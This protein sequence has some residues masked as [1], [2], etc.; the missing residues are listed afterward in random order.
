LFIDKLPKLINIVSKK[1]SIF[2]FVNKASNVLLV[3]GTTLKMVKTLPLSI[4]KA[5]LM[6][7]QEV[8]G[9]IIYGFF[10]EINLYVFYV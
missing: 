3:K 5:L 9:F 7:V 4:V 2:G 10:K 8:L 6:L 1:N